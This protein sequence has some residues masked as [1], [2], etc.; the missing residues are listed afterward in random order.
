MGLRSPES[1][2]S[3]S[4]DASSQ[5]PNNACASDSGGLQSEKRPFLASCIAAHLHRQVRYAENPISGTD[6]RIATAAHFLPTLA[7]S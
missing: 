6:C 4:A 7:A 5:V 1:W 3:I 2:Y